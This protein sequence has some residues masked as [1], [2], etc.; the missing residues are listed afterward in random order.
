MARPVPTKTK[1]VKIRSN[2]NIGVLAP[3]QIAEVEYSQK[4]R[5]LI[6]SGLWTLLVAP[7]E[8]KTFSAPAPKPVVED[9]PVIADEPVAETVEEG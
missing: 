6:E 3:G 5:D 8:A 2:A 4:A 9:E 1:T 7:Q